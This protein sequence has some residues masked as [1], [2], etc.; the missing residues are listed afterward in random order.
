MLCGHGV[1]QFKVGV[2]LPDCPPDCFDNISHWHE[3]YVNSLCSEP[4]HLAQSCWLFK[5][6]SL[7]MREGVCAGLALRQGGVRPAQSSS[8][9]I[10]GLAR[11]NGI[12]TICTRHPRNVWHR[13]LTNGKNESERERE[14]WVEGGRESCSNGPVVYNSVTGFQ[15]PI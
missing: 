12:Y 4:S 10:E 1:T 11:L 6:L 2:S 13:N 14:G 3:L 9:S 7:R 5:A 15:W 8:D